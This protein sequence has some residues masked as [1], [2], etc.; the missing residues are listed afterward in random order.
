M[1]KWQTY[2]HVYRKAGIERTTRSNGNVSVDPER[3]VFIIYHGVRFTVYSRMRR[4]IS[5]FG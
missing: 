2:R 1:K 3:N 4:R 5:S